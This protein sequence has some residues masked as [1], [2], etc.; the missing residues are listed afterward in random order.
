MAGE[1]SLFRSVG[2]FFGKGS[3][4]RLYPPKAPPSQDRDAEG[5]DP[6]KFIV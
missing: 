1:S 6:L 4:N 5:I 3:Y 2:F